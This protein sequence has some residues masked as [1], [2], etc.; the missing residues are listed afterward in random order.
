MPALLARLEI[1]PRKDSLFPRV[2][3]I[4]VPDEAGYT[5]NEPCA[6]ARALGVLADVVG[7]AAVKSRS[8]NLLRGQSGGDVRPTRRTLTF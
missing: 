8:F 6:I 2:S 1:G 4:L 3:A 5:L 7:I